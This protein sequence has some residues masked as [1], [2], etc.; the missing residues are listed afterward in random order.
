MTADWLA[1]GDRRTV[2]I[3]RIERAAL[4]LFLERGIDDV[5]A[6]DIAAAAGCSRATMYRYVGG[7]PRLV[8]AVMVRAAGT[9]VARVEAAVDQVP[10]GR[11]P[12]EAIL[13]AVAAL[14]A[15]PVLRQWL[16]RHRSPDTDEFLA[17]APEL[18]RIATA[19]T[20]IAPDDAAAAWIVRVVL[21]LLTWPLPDA[22]A[23]RQLVER[24]VGPALRAR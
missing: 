14:R 19:L 16:I 20:R 8:R 23:E 11:R 12:V 2:A 21:S 24:F 7:K 6:E 17:E 18:G 9:V 4:A 5:T 15:D 13:A 22:A 3:D 1:G 10:A